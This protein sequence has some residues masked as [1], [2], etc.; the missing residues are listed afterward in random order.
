M[1]HRRHT[2]HT[3]IALWCGLLVGLS[4]VGG[5]PAKKRGSLGVSSSGALLAGDGIG[6]GSGSSQPGGGLTFRLTEGQAPGGHISHN[7]VDPGKP[8][9]AAQTAALLARAPALVARV[10]DTKGFTFR[11]RSLPPPRT[12]KTVKELFPPPSKPP[13]PAVKKAGP[14]RVLRTSPTGEVRM[15]PKLSVTFSQPMVAVTSHKDTVA[16]GVPVKLEPAIAGKWRWIGTRTLLF[17]TKVRLPMATAFRA[18]VPAGTRS[19]TGGILA[20]AKSWSFSTPPPQVIT[21][22]PSWGSQPLDPVFFVGFDQEIDPDAVLARLTL[23]GGGHK[24]PVRRATAAEVKGDKVVAALVAASRRARHRSRW[25]AFVAKERLAPGTNYLVTLGRGTPSV[26]GPLETKEDQTYAFK[27]Y[28]PLKVTWQSCQ[29]TYKCRPPSSLSMTFN[30]ALDEDAFSASSVTVSP[31]IPGMQVVVRGRSLYILGQVKGSTTYTVALPATLKDVHGQTLGKAEER[32]FFF[33]EAAPRLLSNYRSVVVF[34]PAGDKVF[35]VHSI[36]HRQLRVTVRRVKPS[37]WSAYLEYQR[38][39]RWSKDVPPMPGEIV[40]QKTI[41]LKGP[42]DQMRETEIPLTAALNKQGHGQLLVQVSSWPLAA[43]RHKRQYVLAWVQATD[44][45]VDAFADHTT[46]LA[47][48]SRLP[49][50]KPVQGARISIQPTG[51]SGRSGADGLGKVALPAAQKGKRR[52]VL[53]AQKGDDLVMLPESRNYW[54]GGYWYRRSAPGETLRWFVF[55][56]R[57]LYKPKEEVRLKGWVRMVDMGAGGGLRLLSKPG[58]KVGW[59]VHGPRGNKLATGSSKIN[60]LGGFHL[61]FKL[62]DS[63]NLG[64]ARVTLTTNASLGGSYH[65]HSFRVAEFRRPEFEISTRASA[66]PHRVGG[67]ADVQVRAS[68]FA[69]GGLPGAAVRWQVVARPGHFTPPGRSDWTFVG[70]A[71]SWSRR[72]KIRTSSQPFSG[73][74]DSRGAHRLRI[75]FDAVDPPR[76]MS[77]T[78][79]AT[80]TDVNRRTWT[81]SRHLLVHPSKLYVG[82]RTKSFFVKRGAPLR[83]EVIVTDLDGKAVTGRVVGVQASRIE[84]RYLKHKWRRV[85]RD[86]QSC[87]IISSKAPGKC[88]FKTTKGG[89]YIIRGRVT[90]SDGRPNRTSMTR[91]VTGGRLPP[92]NLVEKEKVRLVADKKEYRPGDKARILVQAP[93]APAEGLLTVRRSGIAQVKRFSMSSTTTVLELGIKESHFPSLSVRVDLVGSA[94]RLDPKGDPLPK[95]PR[96]PAYASGNVS[97]SVPP[98]SRSLQV[99][100]SPEKKSLSPG[101][102]TPLRIKISDSSGRPVAGAEVALVAVDEAVLALTGYKLSSPLSVFYPHR[103]SGVRDT[104][105]RALVQLTDP[106]RL[107]A[108]TGGSTPGP[109]DAL[110]QKSAEHAMKKAAPTASREPSPLTAAPGSIGRRRARASDSKNR[111]APPSG[112]SIAVR[113][114]FSAL[115]LFAPS[116]RTDAS[117]E[118]RLTLKVPDNLTRYRVM[119]VAVAGATRYGY[120]EATV[121]ARNPLM[122]RPSAPRFLNFGDRFSL[123]VVVQNQTDQPMRVQVAVRGTN[124]RWTG[125]RG[126]TISIPAND[127][128]EVRFGAETVTAGVARFQVVAAAGSFADAARIQLPVWTPATTEAFA[129]YGTIDAGASVQPV[130]M[131]SGVI[132][133][134]GGLEISTSSTALQALTDAVL[135]IFSY[136]YECSEQ[137][138]SRVLAVAALRDVLSSFQARGLPKGDAI[139]AAMAR[140]LRRLQNMQNDDGGWGFWRRFQRSW[141]FLSVHV[142]HALVRAKAKGFSIPSRMY[143]KALAH[144]KSIERHIPATYSEHT[145][146]VITAY[147]VYVRALAG[148]VDVP[149]ALRTYRWLRRNKGEALEATA[150]LYPVLSG[151]P[152][153]RGEVAQIRKDLNN[154]VTETAGAAHFRTSYSDGSHLILYSDRRVDGLL[155]EGLIKDQPQSDLIPKIVRGLLAHRKRGRWANTQE[156]VW[157][158]LAL[159]R[160]FHTFE[161]TT[162]NFVARVWLGDRFAG[163]HR[164]SG[165]T[166]EQYNVAIPMRLLGEPGKTQKLVLDK[167]GAGRLYYRIGMRYAPA[168]LR[169]PP[170]DHGFVVQRRYEGVDNPSDVMRL[171]DGAWKVKAGARVRVV[172]TMVAHARRYHVALVDPLPAGLEAINTALR[173]AQPAPPSAPPGRRGRWTRPQRMKRALF[174]GP[175]G[176]WRRAWYEHQ[177][178]RDERAEAFTSYLRAG[179]HVYK[180]VT[181]ALTPG[182]FVVPPAKAE[183]MYHPETFGRSAGDRLIVE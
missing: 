169:P 86:L 129:T 33:R 79:S 144:I 102:K 126:K 114:D 40:I 87:R 34:D 120:G 165:R 8:M 91:F 145:R 16:K 146:R 172:V 138:S 60:V 101:G 75:H 135:Y 21:K 154:R 111:P 35:R 140:D 152:S 110:K 88:V 14:L 180:Y 149:K 162:P 71:P 4:T 2:R 115:A 143:T 89:T 46:L 3:G 92:K 157:V 179:V 181:R 45:A 5:C 57:K 159:D 106:A 28:D 124:V 64:R 119:A 26:E 173:G 103:F 38:K 98:R 22:W 132:K 80:V 136:P 161:K 24:I 13:A 155:L 151:A 107:M 63:V 177:N 147:S 43:K 95:V 160:Y 153:A 100:V 23:T 15:A 130:S 44:L 12:G 39:Y 6:V 49:D 122:L 10:G 56:D 182:T 9:T 148:D 131:P 69:G 27:T 52:R 156:N 53:V 137:I 183:E 117:G 65:T 7:K 99:A 93:F 50:G 158:L 59:V 42:I 29:P 20:E 105:L 30:N 104:Y 171:S 54:G 113:K 19:A 167:R 109:T 18:T 1:M 94:R 58:L 108:R 116:V 170:A 176:W 163:Q 84:W 90:D 70:W 77:V 17:E 66:G 51:A 134:F 150:W 78:A 139:K 82:L 41:T 96:R 166:T 83:V 142:T 97:L 76:P 164:F 141:P 121:T 11:A 81:A 25:V 36:S 32:L 74:T 123:P 47:W 62:P 174:G 37:H 175:Q 178:L 112:A 128:R 85:E 127:R 61:K 48:V 72:Q 68:Y 125:A 55:D 67:H 31:K 118:A 168:D 73:V 133:V